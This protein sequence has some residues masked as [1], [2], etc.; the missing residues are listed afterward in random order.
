MR[1]CKAGTTRRMSLCSITNLSLLLCVR[2]Q[3]LDAINARDVCYSRT[4]IVDFF[5]WFYQADVVSGLLSSRSYARVP[6]IVMT[7]LNIISR[8]ETEVQCRGSPA[9]LAVASPT[10]LIS[11]PI[12][13]SFLSDLLTNLYDEVDSQAIWV[14]NLVSDQLSFNQMLRSEVDIAFFDPSNID[15]DRYQAAV[16]GGEYLILPTYLTAFTWNYNAQITPT[17]NIASH[18]L[19]LDMHSLGLVW[20]AGITVIRATHCTRVREKIHS[21][22]LRCSPH[23]VALCMLQCAELER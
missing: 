12:S 7:S 6:S 23:D 9:Y 1:K 20:F 22:L 11:V 5:L 4:A 18:T 21:T 14:K 17:V 19:R 8:L 3:I 2:C 10:R 15:P 16:D 13:I